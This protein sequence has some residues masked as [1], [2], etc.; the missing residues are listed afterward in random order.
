M[1]LRQLIVLTGF[2]IITG[3]GRDQMDCSPKYEERSPVRRDASLEQLAQR[4]SGDLD[5][6]QDTYERLDREL[7]DIRALE[8]GIKDVHYMPRHDGRT[9]ILRMNASRAHRQV[10]CLNKQYGGTQQDLG[11]K[12]TQ[13]ITFGRALNLDKLAELYAAIPGV[14]EAHPNWLTRIDAGRTLCVSRTGPDW[15]YI[16]RLGSGGD[17]TFIYFLTRPGQQPREISRYVM[18]EA[19]G[20]APEPTWLRHYWQESAC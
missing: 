20:D 2:L 6:D 14:L 16:F 7:R 9:L 15:H 18:P 1:S 10:S 12:G 13:Q 5:A 4:I 3:C 11:P 19:R 17:Q 8:A